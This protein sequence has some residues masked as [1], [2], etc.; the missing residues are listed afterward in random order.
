MTEPNRKRKQ[1]VGTKITPESALKIYRR[2]MAGESPES[3][4]REYR[5]TP[6][7]VRQIRD[8]V[9]WSS[10]TGQAKTR[11]PRQYARGAS[12]GRAKFTEDQVRDIYRRAWAGETIKALADEYR[13]PAP[14]IVEIKYGI[15]WSSVTGHVLDPRL[16]RLA[17][18]YV[19]LC[20][21]RDAGLL[22]ETDSAR[23][24]A[25]FATLC[26]LGGSRDPAQMLAFARRVLETDAPRKA[27]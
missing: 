25:L 19:S 11:R 14:R 15:A 20:D 2:V 27:R 4:A 13:R 17:S 5:V 26:E 6:Q 16:Y 1:R 24:D 10:V 3:L 23:I 22:A 8:G 9:T 7:L 12:H 18:E 21:A